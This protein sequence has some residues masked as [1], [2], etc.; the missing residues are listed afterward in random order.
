MKR[1]EREEGAFHA[2]ETAWTQI[3]RLERMSV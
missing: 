2:E 3:Q 1:K